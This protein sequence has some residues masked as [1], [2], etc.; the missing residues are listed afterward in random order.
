[1]ILSGRIWK[2]HDCMTLE[3][4]SFQITSFFDKELPDI[5]E[6]LKQEKIDSIEALFKGWGKDS[7]FY[8]MLPDIETP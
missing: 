3:V 6:Q 2:S 8:T 7:L 4:I 5:Y 1:M